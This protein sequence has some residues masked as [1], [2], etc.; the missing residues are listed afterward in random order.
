MLGRST[1]TADPTAS[2]AVLRRVA[3]VAAE[4]G[5][6]SWRVQALFGLGSH[7]HTHGDPARAVARRRAGAGDGGG[8]ARRRR[9][10]GP[11]AGQR[12]YCSSTAPCAALPLL[13]G[14]RRA[15]RTAAAH[16]PAGHG[17]AVRRD[18]RRARG[19]RADHDRVPRR[20]RRPARTPRPRSPRSG[21]W[22][23]PCPTS[24]AT[25]LETASALL[26]EAVP[27]LLEHGSAIPIDHIGLWALLRTAVGDRDARRP[28]APPKPQGARWRSAT[29]PRSTTPTRSPRAGPGTPDRRR[30][31]L[32]HRRRHARA[33]AV[34][35]PALAAVRAGRRGGRRLG[36]PGARPARRPRRARGRGRGE[37][38]PHLPRPAAH[39]RARRPAAK[40]AR[41]HR[42]CAPGASRPGR[43][44]CSRSSPPG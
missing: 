39:G 35:E 23:A 27:A 24:S 30:R 11:D 6:P 33:P 7:E 4:H 5:L 9:A 28:R 8:H 43:P 37:P 42:P 19:R 31:A 12:A 34:V 15:G 41:W 38:G 1:F 13:R 26:D 20:R 2:D 3:R 44:R 17:R 10:G 25:A 36:R 21:R 22:S 29:G 16:R 18:R 14:R 32:R 40:R